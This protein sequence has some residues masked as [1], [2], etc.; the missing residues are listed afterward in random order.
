MKLIET[1]KY[2]DGQFANLQL[3]QDRMNN[4]RKQLF[5][6]EDHIHLITKLKLVSNKKLVQINL[7]TF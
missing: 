6:L 5:G 4:A 2:E 3:H 7:T 1:I